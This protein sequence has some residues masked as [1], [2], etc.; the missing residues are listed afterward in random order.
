MQAG[1]LNKRMMVETYT[2]IKDR[3]GAPIESWAPAF[4]VWAHVQPLTGSERFIAQQVVP[5]ASS[6]VTM[7][8]RNT[9]KEKDRLKLSGRIFQIESLQ[10]VDERNKELQAICVEV[11]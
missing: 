8:W 7:R 5:T 9:I 4:P 10:N 2:V 3:H 11:R 6:K 1:K